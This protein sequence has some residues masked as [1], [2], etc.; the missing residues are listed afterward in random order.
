MKDPWPAK[1]PVCLAASSSIASAIIAFATI[2]VHEHLDFPS[3]QSAFHAEACSRRGRREAR[4]LHARLDHPRSNPHPVRPPEGNA[5]LSAREREVLRLVATGHVAEEIALQLTISAQTANSHVKNTY[6]KPFSRH[7]AQI[8]RTSNESGAGLHRQ[9]AWQRLISEDPV[10]ALC[11]ARGRKL[12]RQHKVLAGGLE[13]G[14]PMAV[15][16]GNFIHGVVGSQRP[17]HPR[18]E[19]VG[20]DHGAYVAFRVAMDHPEAISR[21]VVLDVVPI[22]EALERCNARFARWWWHWF[23]YAQP[24]KPERAILADPEAWYG[25]SPKHMGAEA[26]EDFRQAIHDPDTVHAMVEDYR[27]GL[28]ITWQRR[29]RGT[30]D[31]PA[32]MSSALI[33]LLGM[34]AK[35]FGKAN[36]NFA[37][38]QTPRLRLQKP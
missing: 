5:M 11:R 10:V 35:T 8:I 20:H 16:L 31:A 26:F 37:F 2:K 3:C 15:L 36:E 12:R 25:G 27:A 29:T 22:V 19:V 24:E 17:G 21:L 38:R 1:R 28:G 33:L 30:R 13:S 32:E 6:R 4:R 9:Q 23:F 7:A 14:Q 18:F 34:P